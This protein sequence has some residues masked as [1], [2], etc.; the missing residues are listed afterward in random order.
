M[1][2]QNA[3]PNMCDENGVSP[4]MHAVIDNNRTLASL[5]MK[6]GADPTQ[7]DNTG[8]DA[9]SCSRSEGMDEALTTAKYMT[10]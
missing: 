5:L 4:L 9:Y 3:D 1:L 8:R 6:H 2:E 10:D 7:K